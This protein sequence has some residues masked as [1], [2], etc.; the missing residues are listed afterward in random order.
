[1]NVFVSHMSELKGI[2]VMHK[3]IRANDPVDDARDIVLKAGAEI[4]RLRQKGMDV[5]LVVQI[6]PQE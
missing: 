5:H 4:E 2:R 1:M 6:E 3:I